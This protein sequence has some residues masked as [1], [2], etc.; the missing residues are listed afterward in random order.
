MYIVYKNKLYKFFFNI[1]NDW[2]FFNND[3]YCCILVIVIFFFLNKDKIFLKIGLINLILGFIIR[4][5]GVFVIFIF[6]LLFC[7]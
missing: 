5:I 1:K 2:F 4:I 6:K 3:L 7:L